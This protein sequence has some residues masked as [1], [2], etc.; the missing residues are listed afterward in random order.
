M[1]SDRP[2][3]LHLM[4]GRP[5][6]FYVLDALALC[7]IDRTVVVVGAGA[8]RITKRISED[9]PDRP[10]DFVEQVRPR[11]TA[12]ATAAGL[13]ALP[14]DDLGDDD[15]VVLAGDLPLLSAET[16]AEL[17]GPAPGRR[18]SLHDRHRPPG[19]PDRPQSRGQGPGGPHPAGRGRRR[20]R[21]RRA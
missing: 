12:D 20:S 7:P 5:M 18:G 15:V 11:G 17:V 19:R 3:P 4:C 21:R 9:L 2:K 8:E 14:D 6:L 1:R 16:V 13:S 10:V